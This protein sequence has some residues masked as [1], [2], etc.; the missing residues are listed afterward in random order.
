MDSQP[1]Q[2]AEIYLAGLVDDAAD[3]RKKKGGKKTKEAVFDVLLFFWQMV[4][5]F[6]L[7]EVC[8]FWNPSCLFLEE[9][10]QAHV[11]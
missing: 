10:Y 1:T 9:T 4:R 2:R 11:R 7:L 8:V 5:V 3:G 6:L